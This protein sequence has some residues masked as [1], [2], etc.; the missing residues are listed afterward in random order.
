MIIDSCLRD[1]AKNA[2]EPGYL[3]SAMRHPLYK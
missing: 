1:L 3:S 2:A